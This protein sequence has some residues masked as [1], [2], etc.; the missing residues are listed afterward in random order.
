[1]IR[2]R[3][4]MVALIPSVEAEKGYEH[5]NQLSLVRTQD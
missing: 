3:Q 1:M 4:C 5:E 2:Q